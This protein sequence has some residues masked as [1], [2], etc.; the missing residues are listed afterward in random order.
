MQVERPVEGRQPLRKVL[1]DR[2][3]TDAELLRRSPDGPA[4][5]DD[6]EGQVAG[7]FLNVRAQVPPLPT[8]SVSPLYVGAET[9]RTKNTRPISAS[10]EVGR[11]SFLEWLEA[12]RLLLDQNN[13]K[14][15][16]FH[17]PPQ[18]TGDGLGQGVL[19]FPHGQV[20]LL[21]E[22]DHAAQHVPLGQDGRGGGDDVALRVV[23][24]GQRGLAGLMLVDLPALHDLGQGGGDALVG[25]LPPAA[26]GDGEAGVPVGDGDELARA[27]VQGLAQLAGEI[28][29]T[30]HEGVFLKH[31]A[32]LAVGEDLQG[33]ALPDAHGAAD[34][35]RDDLPAQVV[36]AAH[37]TSSFHSRSNLSCEFIS[38]DAISCLCSHIVHHFLPSYSR[39]ACGG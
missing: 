14:P 39:R 28:R 32:A 18:K 3:F 27:L 36:D 13:G 1:V 7:A 5:L 15:S 12:V 2:G 19:C 16:G 6:V 37:D 21:A 4:V 17:V 8:L 9:S 22:E 24:H 35:L 10:T 26:A 11:V 23:A 31:D 30:A 25:Q 20:V 33:V 34:L 38:K 29:Q